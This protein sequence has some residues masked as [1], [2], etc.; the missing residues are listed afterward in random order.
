MPTL[1]PLDFSQPNN[2]LSKYAD[3]E[4]KKLIPKNDY[5]TT[6]EYSSTN[7]DAMSDGDDKGRG[8]G[9]FLDTVNGGTKTDQ[10]ERK[11]EIVLPR[12]VY[13]P[14]CCFQELDGFFDTID[15]FVAAFSIKRTDGKEC[16]ICKDFDRSKTLF[17]S[18]ATYLNANFNTTYEYHI[19]GKLMKIID[20]P[21]N[22]K[23][24]PAPLVT[25]YIV[26]L[27]STHF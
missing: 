21:Q 8:T 25:I 19:N 9:V 27:M 1:E 14:N 15:R 23:T 4:R 10:L 17:Q 13:E 16:K 3:Q 2:L 12:V 24:C 26:L 22:A 6:N 18:C 5:K 20:R 7:K 11:S